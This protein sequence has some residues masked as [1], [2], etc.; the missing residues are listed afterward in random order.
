MM[1]DYDLIDGHQKKTCIYD[2]TKLTNNTY[3]LD[4]K[5][6]KKTQYY[7]EQMVVA[8]FSW[9]LSLQNFVPISLLVTL[10]MV[11]FY[12]GK[13][14]GYDWRIYCDDKDLPSKA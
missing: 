7:V 2:F 6:N 14:I 5:I 10:E 3:M 8:Y 9:F 4:C 1:S 11:K 13:F 12:Q